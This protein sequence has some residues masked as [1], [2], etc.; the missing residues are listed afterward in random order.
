M[1]RARS[2]TS[3]DS[4]VQLVDQMLGE[5]R[6]GILHAARNRTLPRRRLTSRRRKSCRSRALRD[7]Q[8]TSSGRSSSAWPMMRSS[9]PGSSGASSLSTSSP[10]NSPAGCSSGSSERASSSGFFDNLLRDDSC[11]ARGC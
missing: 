4:A 3:P 2:P 10:V 6:R 5:R 9:A 8:S 7:C 1:I 11:R